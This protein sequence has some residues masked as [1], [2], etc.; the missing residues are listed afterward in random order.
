MLK[1]F[2]RL[3]GYQ[4]KNYVL[5]YINCGDNLEEPWNILNNNIFPTDKNK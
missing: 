2:E 1:T 5:N 3:V 4:A